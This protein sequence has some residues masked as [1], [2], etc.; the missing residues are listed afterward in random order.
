MIKT[1][2]Y[3]IDKNH[4]KLHWNIKNWDVEKELLELLKHTKTKK[5]K[6]ITLEMIN[7]MS[8][9]SKFILDLQ[10]IIKE[11]KEHCK[12]ALKINDKRL[13]KLLVDLWYKKVDNKFYL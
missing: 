9:T 11:N 8:I 10:K 12:I 3:N 4:I 1:K 7:S 2:H 5:Y 13:Q 6:N